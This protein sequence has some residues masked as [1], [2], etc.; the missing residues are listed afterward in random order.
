MQEYFGNHFTRKFA[1]DFVTLENKTI[2]IIEIKERS[3]E[4]VFLLN[5]EKNSQ[6]FYVRRFASAKKLTMYEFIIYQ[7]EHWKW[8]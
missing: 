3:A 5:K 7:K 1:I 6:E 4:P 8:F 2:A